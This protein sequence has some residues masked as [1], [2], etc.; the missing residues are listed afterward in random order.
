MYQSKNHHTNPG[1]LHTQINTHYSL[2]EFLGTKEN[3]EWYRVYTQANQSPLRWVEASCG[4][5]QI[6]DDG[7]GDGGSD[8]CSV[9]NQFDSHVLALSWQAAFCVTHSSK[10]ECIAIKNNPTSSEWQSFSLHG[11]WPNK[12]KCGTHYGYCGSV[13]HQPSNFCSYPQISLNTDVKQRLGAIMPSVTYGSCLERHEWWKHGTC[14]NNDPNLFFT[15]ATNLVENFNSTR[16]V[17]EFIQPNIGKKVSFQDTIV[18]FDNSFG[19]DAHQHLKLKCTSGLLVEINLA[20]P[21]VVDSHTP[22][23]ELITTSYQI[24]KGNC[25]NTFMVYQPE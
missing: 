14:E 15:L 3:P 8:S 23:K 10:P 2:I 17:T 9:S 12:D 19:E 7:G 5:V 11:L 21:K 18:A 4:F 6:N 13:S 16:F 25:S 1:G 24:D 20:L 22:L